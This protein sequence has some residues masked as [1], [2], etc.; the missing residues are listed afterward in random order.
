MPPKGR[1]QKKRESQHRNNAVSVRRSSE[2]MYRRASI[3]NMLTEEQSESPLTTLMLNTDTD[4][5]LDTP[6][7]YTDQ[8]IVQPSSAQSSSD[9]R[10]SQSH[11]GSPALNDSFL[12]GARRVTAEWN[13]SEQRQLATRHP[14]KTFELHQLDVRS[15]VTGQADS[16]RSRKRSAENDNSLMVADTSSPSNSRPHSSDF[17]AQ[18]PSNKKRQH[19]LDANVLTMTP[20]TDGSRILAAAVSSGT[21]HGDDA[22]TVHESQSSYAAAPTPSSTH[23]SK[24]AGTVHDIDSN[25]AATA[26]LSSTHHSKDAGT[27]HDSESSYAATAAPSSTLRD[28]DAGTVHDTESNY[29]TEATASS[30]HRSTDAGTERD[31]ENCGVAADAALSNRQ[32]STSVGTAS[33]PVIAAQHA[34]VRLQNSTESRDEH[35]G[36]LENC[37]QSSVTIGDIREPTLP[38]NLPRTP[39][40]P[41]HCVTPPSAAPVR[42]LPGNQ[43]SAGLSLVNQRS[44]PV[45]QSSA[46]KMRTRRSAAVT[47]IPRQITAAA[48]KHFAGMRVDAEA[49]DHVEEIADK[50]W[51]NLMSDVQTAACAAKHS[52]VVTRADMESVM[53]RQGLM[54]DRQSL[55]VLIERY[56]PL[57][58]RQALIP[59]ARA[60]NVVELNRF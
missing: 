41:Y 60:G 49:I 11:R 26:V 31:T 37:M 3:R 1:D 35:V 34:T 21:Q 45:T 5:I 57:E 46:V 42:V 40:L 22:V 33:T 9:R 24:D 25:H 14:T 52:A 13:K 23:R 47:R 4:R 55:N 36:D 32:C 12:P 10:S 18:C 38:I 8:T 48:L 16:K 44:R 58:M 28:E 7:F 50:F 27:V 17:T 56:L 39:Q 2:S 59:V 15:R 29:A 43:N 19:S 20:M 54:P 53:Q 51:K 30:T 6:Q